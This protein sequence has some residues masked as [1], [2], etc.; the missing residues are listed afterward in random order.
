MTDSPE[1]P[2]A[3]TPATEPVAEVEAETAADFAPSPA[4]DA[5]PGA[6]ATGDTVTRRS[7]ALAMAACLLIGG[8]IGWLGA[9]AF[10]DDAQPVSAFEEGRF[11][12]GGP[13][14]DGAHR[15]GPGGQG[16]PDGPRGPGG[17]PGRGP[18]GGWDGPDGGWDGRGGPD[19]DGPQ[20]DDERGSDERPGQGDERDDRRDEDVEGRDG[21]G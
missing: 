13:W 3:S 10:D 8:A 12:G 17:M 20:W 15:Q 7:A 11:P 4:D 5:V 21:D 1:D 14:G 16:F 6:A 2:T 9:G 18:G 19:G